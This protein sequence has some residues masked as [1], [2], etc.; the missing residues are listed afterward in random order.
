DNSNGAY[1]A[2]RHLLERGRRSI[3]FLHGE[4]Q[5]RI[6]RDKVEGFHQALDEF[7][8][9]PSNVLISLMNAD[10]VPLYNWYLIN[11]IPKKLEVSSFNAGNNEIV[12]ETLVLSYQYFKYYDPISVGLDAAAGLTASLDINIGI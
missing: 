2:P 11:A 12:V 10:H 8:F 7:R 9:K 5:E 6:N 3:V 1:A 4:L